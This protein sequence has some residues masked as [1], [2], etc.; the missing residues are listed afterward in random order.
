MD[1]PGAAAVG[2]SRVRGATIMPPIIEF[3]PT[4]QTKNFLKADV[5]PARRATTRAQRKNPQNA[6]SAGFLP[7]WHARLEI[8]R[9]WWDSNNAIKLLKNKHLTHQTNKNTRKNTL[10]LISL[11]KKL[12]EPTRFAAAPKDSY[13]KA[14]N[15]WMAGC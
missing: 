9:R 3:R 5:A 13:S 2:A 11:P 14:I 10:T 6:S 7:A 1:S 12:V 4:A 8:W 15:S